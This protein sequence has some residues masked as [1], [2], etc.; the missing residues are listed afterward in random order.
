MVFNW[1]K[2]KDT[3]QFYRSLT[4]SSIELYG[5][6]IRYL[7]K[8]ESK[9][10]DFGENPFGEND[11]GSNK[12]RASNKGWNKIYGEDPLIAY[13]NA[14]PMKAFLENYDFYEGTHQI[15]NKFG[16]SMADEIT[17]SIEIDRFRKIMEMNGFSYT[18]PEEG[19][20]I[21]FELTTAKN[22]KFQLFEINY[23]NESFSYFAFG[24]LTT[25]KIRCKLFEYSSQKI[26]TGEEKIDIVKEFQNISIGDNDVIEKESK[27]VTNWNP[28]DPFKDIFD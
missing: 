21:A 23:V 20:L 5:I 13:K 27:K 6:P 3:Q 26:E 16:F 15:F 17:L 8:T 18:R 28:D 24:Q 9:Q 11:F 14:I 1:F 12:V 22:D 10:K 7:P 4:S 25:Y 2:Q 19:D